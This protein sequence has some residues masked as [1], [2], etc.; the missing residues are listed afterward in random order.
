M[1]QFKSL[2][3]WVAMATVLG[4]VSTAVVPQAQAQTAPRKIL[5][6]AS[7]QDVPNFDPHVATGYSASALLRN[8]YDP[9]VRVEGNPPQVKPRKSKTS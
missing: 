2:W 5:V 8:L 4:A 1:K 3:R 7:N 6:V 9:L